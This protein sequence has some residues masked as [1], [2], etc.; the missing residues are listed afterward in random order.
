MGA[1]MPLDEIELLE[2]VEAKDAVDFKPRCRRTDAH[3]QIGNRMSGNAEVA[4]DDRPLAKLGSA[5]PHS[6]VVIRT[7]GV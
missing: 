3:Q 4:E 1:G 7:S 5:L 2:E 6:E